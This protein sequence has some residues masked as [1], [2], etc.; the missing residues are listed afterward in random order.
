MVPFSSAQYGEFQDQDVWQCDHA[1]AI[2]Y[3]LDPIIFGGFEF[4]HL[5]H[6]DAIISQL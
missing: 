1:D 2:G 4:K 3:N 5:P 6:Y